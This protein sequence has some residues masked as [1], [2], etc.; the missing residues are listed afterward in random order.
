MKVIWL[1]KTVI[2]RSG[3]L[4]THLWET[5]GAVD[6]LE[7][8]VQDNLRRYEE[9]CERYSDGPDPL[10]IQLTRSWLAS[11]GKQILSSLKRK[12]RAA[13]PAVREEMLT[14]LRA[15]IASGAAAAERDMRNSL[16]RDMLW[17]WADQIIS[18]VETAFRPF[19]ETSVEPELLI[20]PRGDVKIGASDW[21]H[22]EAEGRRP[23]EPMTRGPDSPLGGGA[24]A[25]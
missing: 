6:A 18:S 24:H 9:A 13:D 1:S 10:R 25:A 3:G 12:I 22:P 21:T 23:Y 2:E 20:V 8:S 4:D 11:E 14:A 16:H 5:L 19:P 15:A 7:R 17:E